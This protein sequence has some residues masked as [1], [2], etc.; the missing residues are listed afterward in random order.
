MSCLARAIPNDSFIEH[1]EGST[2][3]GVESVSPFYCMALYDFDSTD[4]SALR[5]R[6]GDVIEVLS[7][8][9]RQVRALIPP[10]FPQY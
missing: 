2:P 5:F 4:L 9:S 3:N 1:T 10:S 7:T 6:A 8:L